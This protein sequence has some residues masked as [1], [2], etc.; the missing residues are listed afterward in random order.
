MVITGAYAAA[1]ADVAEAID[2]DKDISAPATQL[3]LEIGAKVIP[4]P[5]KVCNGLT[6][7]ACTAQL[8]CLHP[9]KADLSRLLRHLMA[10][11][12]HSL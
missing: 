1:S 12:T 8:Q 4:H 6:P 5:D 7:L 2:V 9:R 10:G 3:R 11:K